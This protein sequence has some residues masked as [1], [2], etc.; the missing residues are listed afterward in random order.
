MMMANKMDNNVEQPIEKKEKPHKVWRKKYIHEVNEQNDIKYR[1][2]LSYRHL[3][4]IAWVFLAIAQVSIILKFGATLYQN[5]D[6]YGVWPNV[7]SFFSSFMSPLFLL[8]SFAVVLTA[9]DGYRRLIITYTGIALL[10]IFG[11]IFVYEYYVVGT[12]AIA[13]GYSDAN[14]MVRGFFRAASTNGFITFN[15]FIDLLLCTLV[16]FFTNYRPTKYFQGKKIVIFRLFTLLPIF[17][18]LG[19]IA[20]KILIS[21]NNLSISPIIFPFLTTKPP[22]TFFIFVVLALFMKNREKFYLKKGKTHEEYLQF[23]KTNVNSWHFSSF[24]SVTIAI[25]A[26]IDIIIFVIVSMIVLTASLP[27]GEVD[28]IVVIQTFTDTFDKL[29]SWGLGKTATMILIIPLVLLFDYRKT[30]KNN[31]IDIIIPAGGIALLI[32]VY[33]EGGYEVIKQYLVNMIRESEK[34]PEEAATILLD[35][36]KNIIRKK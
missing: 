22:V 24:L 6:M 35:N 36:I 12:F 13:V 10:I 33:L 29:I 18:E 15:I 16:T 32:L 30:Y 17:Y 7:L 26:I 4:I 2:P 21:T 20:I 23:Q 19:S 8:A 11:F 27:S 14:E 3:R 31:Y 25:S 34:E 1:G 9:K 28:D 5:E